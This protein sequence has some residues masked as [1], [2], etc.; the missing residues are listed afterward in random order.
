MLIQSSFSEIK[1][2]KLYI[3]VWNRAPLNLSNNTRIFLALIKDNYEEHRLIPEIIV[4]PFAPETWADIWRIEFDVNKRPGLFAR[5]LEIFVDLR[6]DVLVAETTAV[7]SDN[8]HTL[9]FLVDMSKYEMQGD[10]TP[11]DRRNIQNLQLK[12][13]FTVLT[14]KLIRCLIFSDGLTPRIR[15]RRLHSYFRCHQRLSEKKLSKPTEAIVKKGFVNIDKLLL[16]DIRKQLKASNRETLR[17]MVL[18]DSKDRIIR[19]LFTLPNRGFL[20]LRIHM[21]NKPIVLKEVVNTI[22]DSNFEIVR[23]HLRLGLYHPPKHLLREMSNTLKYTT[24]DMMVRTLSPDERPRDE[25]LERF[26]SKRVKEN[27][28]LAQHVVEVSQA[29]LLKN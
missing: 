4:T 20:H 24:L 13:L 26:I 25:V 17:S 10:N 29:N 23:S 1:D 16:T 14:A 19:I 6:I 15:I 11:T 21:S 9:S 18:S 3:P 12:S 8:Q 2:N 27:H 22:K 5:V 7:S 28:K